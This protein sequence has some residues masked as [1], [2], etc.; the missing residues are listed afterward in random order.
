[1]VWLGNKKNRDGTIRIGINALLLS[2]RSGYRR[3]GIHNYIYQVLH[4]LPPL[5]DKTEYT[6]FL[7]NQATLEA[8]Q[9]VR[10]KRSRWPTDRPIVR[11]LWE[12]SVWPIIA[13][14][15]NFDLLHSMAF[16][17][18]LIG[19]VPAVVTVYDLSF[20]HYPDSFPKLQQAYLE[21]QTARSC[22][23]AK[24]VITI[25]QSS[26]QDVHH[27]FKIPLDNIDVVVP[28]VDS[29][30]RPI[31]ALEIEAFRQEK[32]LSKKFILHVGTLQ[33]RKNI[34]LLLQ[35]VAE[36]GRHDVD[37]V[38]IGGRG[39]LYEQI[40][41]Q[42]AQL[43]ITN[44]VHFLGY[45]PDEELP[46]WYNSASLLAFPSAYEGF[47]LPVVE[48]LACGTPVVAARSSSIPEAGG[49]AALYF[50]PGNVNELAKQITAILEDPELAGGLRLAGLKQARQFS[51]DRAGR[52]TAQVYHR[53]LG[54]I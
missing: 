7:A 30:Y 29:I 31:P 14:L 4:A 37:L 17:L 25:S 11:I 21:S 26:R 34:P 49:D 51:W 45:V 1:M 8:K 24:R 19:N 38:L 41:D 43:G 27:F 23:K 6:V 2:G 46:L 18:P 33:P 42:V 35:A 28:G 10:R 44:Q 20:I 39:W 15:E 54:L 48:A 13:K 9:G 5:P 50:D 3:A 47:G 52:E 32:G 22:Q 40:F 53:A 36:I 12:Q 16:V